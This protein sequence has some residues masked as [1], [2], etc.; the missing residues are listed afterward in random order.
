MTRNTIRDYFGRNQSSDRIGAALALL[1]TKGL[2]RNERKVS[3]GRPVETWF[4][5]GEAH[6]G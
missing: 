6:C 3:G 1:M 4:A 2:A 5:M